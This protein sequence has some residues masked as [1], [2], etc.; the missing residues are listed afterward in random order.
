QKNLT[1]YLLAH[2]TAW[3]M[4]VALV[5]PLIAAQATWRTA[6]TTAKNP[7]TRTPV[8]IQAKKAARKTLEKQLR[9][10]AAAYLARNPLVHDKDRVAMGITVRKTTRT[11][12]PVPAKQPGM[13]ITLVAPGRVQVSFFDLENHRRARAPFTSGVEMASALRETAPLTDADFTRSHF[14]TRSP[15]TFDFDIADR[16]KTLWLRLRWENSR[17]KKGPWTDVYQVI[18]P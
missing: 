18:I 14:A 16:G 10:V 15:F 8:A 1:T 13:R 9:F 7:A 2:I 17:G 4:S 3:G 6:R 5:D 11:P 12:Q